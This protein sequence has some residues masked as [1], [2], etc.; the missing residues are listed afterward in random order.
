M[1]RWLE[2]AVIGLG[3]VVAVGALWR[4]IAEPLG[5]APTEPSVPVNITAPVVDEVEVTVPTPAPAD[6]PGVPPSV[7]AVLSTAGNT[8]FL[9]V[10]RL[11]AELPASVVSVLVEAEATLR[12]AE[13][14]P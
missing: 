1:P 10:D 3:I 4:T 6:L 14:S 5:A 9:A 13:E 11:G 2:F 8:T 7:G 12:I